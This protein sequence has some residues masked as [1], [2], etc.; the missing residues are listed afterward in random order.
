MNG[1]LSYTTTTKLIDDIDDQTI[2]AMRQQIR[3]AMFDGARNWLRRVADMDSLDARYDCCTWNARPEGNP[4]R[5][6][7]MDHLTIPSF[8]TFGAS[9][10]FKPSLAE[11]YAAIRRFVPDYSRIRWMVVRLPYEDRKA[12]VDERHHIARLDLFGESVQEFA[13]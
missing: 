11:C 6:S 8:H 10:F 1:F 5:W 12:V 9:V 4:M 2:V 13:S 3:L 7:P